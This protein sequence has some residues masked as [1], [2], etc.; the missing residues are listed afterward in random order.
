MNMKILQ[1]LYVPLENVVAVCSIYSTG[2]FAIQWRVLPYT[3]HVI[4]IKINMADWAWITKCERGPVT[5]LRRFVPKPLCLFNLPIVA[6]W[7]DFCLM[8]DFRVLD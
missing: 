2:W 3:A 5:I 6:Q 4:P 8:S 1:I 7:I